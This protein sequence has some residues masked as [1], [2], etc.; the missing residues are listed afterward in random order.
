[1]VTIKEIAQAAGLSP[2]T[3]S[4]VLGGKAAQRK[5]SSETQNKI[6]EIA[7]QLGYQ[8]NIAARS[9]RG[10]AGSDELQIAMFWAQDFRAGMMIRFWD[11]LRKAMEQQ[12]RPIRLV[13]YPY[14]NG[15][16]LEN[17]SLT[18]ATGCHGAIVCN[19]DEADLQFL[20]DT[21]LAI[22][23][24]L[25][26]RTCPGYCSV[27]VDDTQIGAQAARALSGQGCRT[28][29]VLTGPAA[30]AGMETRICG[31][32]AEAEFHG[33][34]VAPDQS[35][36]NSMRG[37]YDA[38]AA[39]LQGAW[40]SARPD[41]LFCGSA[42]I[43]HG[44]LRAFWD[45]GLSPHEQPRVVAVGNG[46]EDLDISSIPSLSVVDVP[47]EKMA[48]KC[49]QILLDLLEGNAPADPMCLLPSS[50]IPRESCGPLPAGE[51]F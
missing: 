50:Y 28:A 7:R 11:G 27:N 20:R 36:E 6:L 13:I 9:L 17:R 26:N 41:A 48:A 12:K 31:F 49:L 21:Q 3:V 24:V 16:L 22:P 35:C 23:V 37:G 2:S 1:M 45:A 44:A 43:A 34:S 42:M 46:T 14:T 5:I 29:A 4:I 32:R 15:R 8:P 19:A 30:F 10:G 39:L 25:Y 47:M 38:A 51:A 18:S 40:M 33:M